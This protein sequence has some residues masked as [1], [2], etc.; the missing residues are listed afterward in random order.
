[1]EGQRVLFDASAYMLFEASGDS[2]AE[3]FDGAVEA[4]SDATAEDDAQSC[5]C[6]TLSDSA[7]VH[8]VDAG[9]DDFD[10]ADFD[11]CSEEE[12]GGGTSEEEDGVVDQCCRGGKAV[13]PEGSIVAPA[14]AAKEKLNISKGCEDSN[15]KLMN[16]REMDRLFWE[17]CLAS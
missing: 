13:P 9:G 1:M 10:G 7:G 3:Y 12:D 4:E 8:E 11:D 14:P 15:V 17:A 6:G 2:E 5:S 16:D